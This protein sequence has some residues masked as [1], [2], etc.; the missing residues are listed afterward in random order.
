MT[1]DRSIEVHG[2]KI[3]EF[4]WGGC[5]VT[6]VNDRKYEGSYVEAVRHYEKHKEE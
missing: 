6:Y 1:A 5:W 4:Y 3:E 2:N